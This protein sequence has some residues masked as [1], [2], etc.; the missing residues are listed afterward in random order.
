MKCHL[1]LNH[2]DVTKSDWKTHC[3][4]AYGYSVFERPA[5]APDD[6]PDKNKCPN[7]FAIV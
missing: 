4:W 2:V 7:C 5:K 1:A 6:L 3:G